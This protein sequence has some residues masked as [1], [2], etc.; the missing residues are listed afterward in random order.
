VLAYE[1]GKRL[2]FTWKPDDWAKKDPASIVSCSFKATKTG[3]TLTLRHS[4]L[5]NR[6]E[7]QNHKT[8][9]TKFVF[10]PLN[11]YLI[12]QQNKKS[13]RSIDP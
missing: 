4:G 12:S 6:R 3:C 7:R 8:G 11:M 2:S 1:P 5:P 10:D 9:W 13:H